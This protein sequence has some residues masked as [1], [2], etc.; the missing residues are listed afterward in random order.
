MRLMH[1]ESL[2][3]KATEQYRNYLTE[4][5]Q[6]ILPWL[7]G[8]GERERC[9]FMLAEGLA[10]PGDVRRAIPIAVELHDPE[11]VATLMEYGRGAKPAD[12]DTFDLDDL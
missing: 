10:G 2:S 3:D 4:N 6:E 8:K 7:V 12:F 1:P 9:M 11:L 5:A